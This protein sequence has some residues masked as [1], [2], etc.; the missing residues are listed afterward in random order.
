MVVRP[1]AGEKRHAARVVMTVFAVAR[2]QS[3]FDLERGLSR[4]RPTPDR[5]QGLTVVRMDSRYPASAGQLHRGNA[6]DIGPP[7]PA[8]VA[9]PLRVRRPD[10]LRRG[11]DQRAVARFA[12]AERLLGLVPVVN[13]DADAD[14]LA[15]CAALV[16]QRDR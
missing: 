14:P 1:R 15:D 9:D 13:V 10:Q 3:E 4:A 5:A 12:L 6:G 2:M 7:R 16:A 8:P 11:L